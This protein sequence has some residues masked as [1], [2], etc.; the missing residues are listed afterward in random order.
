M[1]P[2]DWLGLRA[3]VA[4]ELGPNASEGE[5]RTVIVKCEP[6]DVFLLGVRVGLWRV[7]GKAVGWHKAA[8]L[9]LQPSPPV[10]RGGVTDVRGRWARRARW[11]GIPSASGPSRA[12][13]VRSARWGPGSQYA[14][15]R[16]QVADVP[17][18][19]PE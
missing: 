2:G 8:V 17:I 16:R 7:F 15:H 9:R 13:R 14:G 6:H 11:G 12:R 10:R 5:R 1:R 4:L 19:H 18:Y 3:S